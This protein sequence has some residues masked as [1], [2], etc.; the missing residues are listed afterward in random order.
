MISLWLIM[1]L[2]GNFPSLIKGEL[3][4]VSTKTWL[5]WSI[6]MPIIHQLYVLVC[7]RL[8]LYN[9]AISKKFGDKGFLYFKIGFAVLI[10]ARPIAI[11][12]LAISNSHTLTIN[13]VVGYVIVGLL[14]MPAIYLFYSVKRYFGMDRTFGVD[15][16]EPEKIKIVPLVK[17]GI[18]KYTSN[19]MYVYGFFILWIPGLLFLS[20]AALLIALF[21]HIYIWI[22][23]YY[24]EKPDM[25]FIYGRDEK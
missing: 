2:C 3:W 13:P 11:T 20:K 4:N 22:H 24:T 9:K 25:D 16:F 8:E 19:G 15:H 21:N 14:L 23:Y 12:M 7:W 6:I 5:V 18:F 17:K 10:M 1:F